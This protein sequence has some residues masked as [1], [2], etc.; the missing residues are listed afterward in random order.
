MNNHVFA[1]RQTEKAWREK[2]AQYRTLIESTHGLI[3]SVDLNGCIFQEALTNVARH[4]EATEV[5]VSL[6]TDGEQICLAVADNGI[7]ITLSQAASPRAIGL[8]GMRERLYPWNGQFGI[9][10][11]AGEGIIVRITAPLPAR[12]PA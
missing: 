9:Q 2:G 10:G 8:L 7:G 6:T 12:K 3:Q 4:A 11:A 1:A 5:A